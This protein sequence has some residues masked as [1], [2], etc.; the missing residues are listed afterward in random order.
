MMMSLTKCKEMKRVHIVVVTDE[1][2]KKV[3]EIPE[4]IQP[5]PPMHDI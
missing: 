2:L 4:T 3:V 1:E 5:L